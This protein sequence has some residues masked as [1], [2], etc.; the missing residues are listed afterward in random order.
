[1]FS[2]HER[3][4]LFGVTRDQVQAARLALNSF[5]LCVRYGLILNDAII[6]T[7]ER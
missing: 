2:I 6:R 7:Q 5:L 3:A 4:F 1:M